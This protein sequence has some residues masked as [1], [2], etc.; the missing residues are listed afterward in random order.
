MKS[1]TAACPRA[2]PPWSAA[3]PAAARPC[4]PWSSSSG[5]PWSST[6]PGVFMSFEETAEELA[7]NVASLGFDLPE[8]VEQKAARP[9]SCLYRA[10]RDRG[11]RGIRSG[12]PVHPPGLRDRRHRRQTG[13][14][15]H[16][17][18]P[19]RRPAQR[20]DPALRTA[21][22][23]PLAE[24][25]G[26]HRHHHRRAGRRH[27]DP[28]RHRG[29]RLRR[30]H[31]PGPPGDGPDGHPPHALRQVPRLPARHQRVSLPDR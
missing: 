13:G 19:V 16:H 18:G 27:P 31:R 29:I 21:P 3:R 22:P 11:D 4:W 1:P 7:K 8:L 23:L 15:G 17:R 9:G 5:G 14:A 26:G 6:S 28:P 30:G 25:Q 12:G 20:A 2:G 24:R 10:Q